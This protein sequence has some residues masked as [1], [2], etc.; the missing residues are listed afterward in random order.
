MTLSVSHIIVEECWPVIFTA[1]LQCTEISEHFFDAQLSLGPAAVL[2]SCSG[3]DVFFFSFRWPVC[4]TKF[5]S[6]F[7]HRTDDLTSDCRIL[8]LIDWSSARCPGPVTQKNNPAHH[9]STSADSWYQLFGFLQTWHCALWPNAST[10]VQRTLFHK[11]A[12]S[13]WI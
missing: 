7:G 4:M 3:L 11:F 13:D 5:R 12:W 8:W 9:P 2:Q 10:S 1:L 6:C